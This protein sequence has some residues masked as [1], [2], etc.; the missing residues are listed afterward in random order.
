MTIAASMS[1]LTSAAKSIEIIGNNIANAQTIGFKTSKA[2][3]AAALASA[4]GSSEKQTSAGV[5]AAIVSQN[6]TQGNLTQSN[7]PL[8][9]AIMGLGFFRLSNPDNRS[10]SYSRDGQFGLAYNSA[11]PNTRDLVNHN[12]LRVTGYLAE[13]ETDPQGVIVATGS[14]QEIVIDPT[15][16]AAATSNVKLGATL[17]GR[18]SPPL[19]APFATNDPL[20]YNSSSGIGVFDSAG[21]AHDLRMYFS[22]AGPG[23]FWNLHTTLDGASQIGPINLSF[24]ANGLM[25]TP[26]PL[27][28]TFTLSG[29]GSLSVALNL[30]GTVQFGSNFTVDSISQDGYPVGALN[31]SGGFSVGSDG[32]IRA[33]YSNGQSRNVAQLVLANFANPGGLIS[34]G[35][36]QWTEN[37]DPADGSGKLTLDTPGR[38]MGSGMG[39]IQSGAK[40]LSNTDLNNELVA[41]IEQQR[42]YQASA[43]TFKILDQILQKLQDA[44]RG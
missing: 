36:N 4:S 42:N 9:M 44:T 31:N 41:L 10:I 43:Q 12:G 15:M 13:Y 20:T 37:K 28:Q 23:S 19:A 14:P 26:M 5:G 27:A 40:E 30:S 34:V 2:S 6:F 11:R 24:D 1:G 8:D 3:F 21:G 7:K 32:V 18:L 22:K 17:D 35:D 38:S 39:A 29:G 33:S 25:A 16:P